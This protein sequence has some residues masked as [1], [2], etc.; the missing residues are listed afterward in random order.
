MLGVSCP[1]GPRPPPEQVLPP[2]VDGLLQ[3]EAFDLVQRDVCRL[4]LAHSQGDALLELLFSLAFK[5][6]SPPRFPAQL[7]LSRG[8]Q[9]LPSTGY[10]RILHTAGVVVMG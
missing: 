8:Q 7:Q 10:Q 1:Q 6:K 5:L 2:K 4:P 3:G 9:L